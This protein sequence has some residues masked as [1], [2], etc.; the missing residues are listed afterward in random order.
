MMEVGALT[1]WMK[2]R[3]LQTDCRCICLCFLSQHH[4]TQ[5]MVSNNGGSWYRM[6]RVL[7]NSRYSDQ[8]CQQLIHSWLKALAV[9][10]SRPPG[11]LLVVCCLNWIEQPSLAQS[12]VKGMS[13][14]TVD[15]DVCVNLSSFWHS[16]PLRLNF[17]SLVS[18]NKLPKSTTPHHRR[19]CH[20]CWVA[21][22]TVWSHMACEFP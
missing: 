9:N 3:P 17:C 4:K 14:D 22:N 21:G 18:I 6:Q 11:R 16:T 13:S 7:H 1:V 12:A 20:L 2:W 10:L 8:D 19:E 15:L 5:K